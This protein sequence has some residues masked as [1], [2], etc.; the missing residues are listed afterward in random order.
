MFMHMGEGARRTYTPLSLFE[1]YFLNIEQGRP[2]PNAHA[3]VRE[4][5]R[6][7]NEGNEAKKAFERANRMVDED[8]EDS[9]RSSSI[10]EPSDT[11]D[12]E[13]SSA[14]RYPMR[15]RR[16]VRDAHVGPTAKEQE[17][18]RVSMQDQRPLPPVD[19]N[20]R[21][22]PVGDSVASPYSHH[23][24]ANRHS[25]PHYY[26]NQHHAQLSFER[27]QGYHRG[28]DQGQ[29]FSGYQKDYYAQTPDYQGYPEQWR[30]SY[31]EAPYRFQNDMSGRYT[32]QYSQPYYSN[33]FYEQGPSM[34]PSP[35][36]SQVPVSDHGPE[37]PAYSQDDYENRAL[38]EASGSDQRP[39]LAQRG[40]SAPEH[41][42][43]EFRGF[44]E[45]PP[46]TMTGGH[47]VE[48]YHHVGSRTWEGGA[49][50]ENVGRVE[51]PRQIANERERSPS[52]ASTI[53]LQ[54][55]YEAGEGQHHVHQA[56]PASRGV[57]RS[58]DTTE[59]EPASHHHSDHGSAID[60]R[61]HHYRQRER[62]AE[63]PR[64]P[65]AQTARRLFDHVATTSSYGYVPAL[66]LAPDREL[67]LAG[68]DRTANDHINAYNTHGDR[69]LSEKI[70]H[71]RTVEQREH[72]SVNRSQLS[73][74]NSSGPAFSASQK[75]EPYRNGGQGP[76]K[77]E[78]PTAEIEYA[79]NL[80]VLA[81]VALMQTEGLAADESGDQ[82]SAS[83][84]N[85]RK[86]D[87]GHGQETSRLIKRCDDEV[88]AAR[89]ARVEKALRLD[90]E[91]NADI[92]RRHLKDD[93][94]E[95]Q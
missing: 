27:S 68:P 9:N 3:F 73:T 10:H 52:T 50:L 64:T 28:Q 83:G 79:G 85:T 38:E 23:L 89:Q 56:E 19:E 43:Q 80:E 77:P 1:H 69:V 37:R 57:P 78:E 62:R 94:Q 59:S 18:N 40:N 36:Y 44:Y 33:N 25:R 49:Q 17:R 30:T 74:I 7:K 6:M 93:A 82:H 88:E 71:A 58:G 35:E 16:K 12:G 45:G 67:P 15:P 8:N 95:E 46:H 34:Q 61:P 92:R 20:Y 84:R 75:L 63:Y 47:S 5:N 72:A 41:A 81:R 13:N 65:E 29:G 11:G 66:D 31:G 87:T 70:S 90:A 22:R 21:R 26:G 32:N 51:G 48:N 91:I 14:H 53:L 76:V 24:E 4:Y 42:H 60:T 54:D 86:E 39:Y 2:S 55:A